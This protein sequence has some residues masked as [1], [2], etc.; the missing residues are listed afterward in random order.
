MVT[1]T[2]KLNGNISGT[3]RWT[4]D[5]VFYDNSTNPKTLVM[6]PIEAPI[7][8]GAW[9][10]NV[11]QSQ[12]LSGSNVPTEG[13]TYLIQHFQDI[14]TT[15]FYFLSGTTYTGA[16]HQHTDTFWYTG[17]VH[18]VTSVRLDRIQTTTKQLLQPPVHTIAPDVQTTVDFATL[19]SIPASVPYLD[20]SATRIAELLTTNA[21]YIN[22]ISTKFNYKGDY[23]A[24][25]VY[26]LNDVINTAGNSFI[27]RNPSNLSGQTPPASGSNTN[28]QLLASKGDVGAGTTAS[29]VGWNASAWAGSNQA[30]A[31]EDVRAA[32]ASVTFNV[33]L[34]PYALKS[35]TAPKANAIFSGTLKRP[36]LTYPVATAE[37]ATEI[38]TAQ[39]IEDALAATSLAKMPQPIVFVRRSSNQ[40]ICNDGGTSGTATVIWNDAVI[41]AN[42]INGSSAFVVPDTGSYIFGLMLQMRGRANNAYEQTKITMRGLLYQIGFGELGNF[43]R[44]DFR[45]VYST[46]LDYQAFGFRFQVTLNQ[47]TQ[48]DV[49]A[50]IS[51]SN[52]ANAYNPDGDTPSAI[53]GSSVQNYL[54][55]WKA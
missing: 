38:P 44:H 14:V 11:P 55:I 1:V 53:I 41:G 30:A 43:F 21:T 5:H 35:E 34:S 37:K 27:W 19:V 4:A 48:V 12:N 7:V 25:T 2:G 13:I 50:N 31:R 29:I 18:D 20:I 52:G 40:T 42:L 17:S 23:N 28:W 26:T 3:V 47:N 39:Y 16:T 54:L 45:A 9:T 10:I 32:I 24:S 49:R 36:A 46:F 51:Y 8:A 22:R 15:T 33:D 6:L